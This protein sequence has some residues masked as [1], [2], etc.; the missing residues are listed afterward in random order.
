MSAPSWPFLTHSFYSTFPVFPPC[1]VHFPPRRCLCLDSPFRFWGSIK[2]FCWVEAPNYCSP[3]GVMAPDN[4]S[5]RNDTLHWN[6]SVIL[7]NSYLSSFSS[8]SDYPFDL[9]LP[10]PFFF[11]FLS[12][13]S[14]PLLLNSSNSHMLLSV[15]ICNYRE[16]YALMNLASPICSRGFSKC[17]TFLFLLHLKWISTLSIS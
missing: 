15:S 1:P 17:N 16:N 7:Q 2:C 13:I 4:G 3:G 5:L 12:P 9:D 8:F 6:P 11:F 10:L 14:T